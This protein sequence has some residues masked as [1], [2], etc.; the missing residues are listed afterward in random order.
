MIEILTGFGMEIIAYDIYPDTDSGT[1]YVT[2]D[3]LISKS[4]VISLHTPLTPE[5]KH[6]I[7]AESISKM[8]D[9]VILINTARGGLI[10]TEDLIK[11]LETNKFAGVGLDVC[12][13]ESEYFF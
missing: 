9:G 5:T 7:D 2:F 11:G 13:H 1:K 12:E 4:D 6:I 3:E 10:K 8:K